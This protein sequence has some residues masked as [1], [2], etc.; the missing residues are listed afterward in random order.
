MQKHTNAGFT[1]VEIIVTIAVFA[2]I[3][4]A[5]AAMI[6]SLNAINDRARELSVAHALTQ[7]QVEELRSEGFLAIETGADQPFSVE[8]PNALNELSAT[9]TV[10]LYDPDGAGGE[11]PDPSL[12]RIVLNIEYN[13]HGETRRLQYQTYLGELGVG[14]Y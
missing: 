1:L 9:Y 2:I 7:N 5:I 3:L 8:L 14:Q 6:V 13:D 11:D 12:K 10:S 4:P